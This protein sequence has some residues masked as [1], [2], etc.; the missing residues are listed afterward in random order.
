MEFLLLVIAAAAV[1]GFVIHLR[2]R[3]AQ[4]PPTPA[5]TS[6]GFK[7][8]GAGA[9]ASTA[10]PAVEKLKPSKLSLVLAKGRRRPPLWPAGWP[11]PLGKSKRSNIVRVN[12]D[13]EFRSL[14]VSIAQN[15]FLYEDVRWSGTIRDQPTGIPKTVYD[16][17]PSPA[18]QKYREEL[19]R[20]SRYE[21]DFL[22][23]TER[24]KGITIKS[25][26]DA[27]VYELYV[28]VLKER[29][30]AEGAAPEHRC[31]AAL[32]AMKRYMLKIKS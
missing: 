27:S 4:A 26:K 32:E 29:A 30:L 9:A 12:P 24:M 18:A 19:P 16:A 14:D 20:Y 25:T 3:A 10:P 13:V 17:M 21:T 22:K 11:P 15:L 8:V 7:E 23:V 28:E 5:V 1:A 31:H 2:R 6:T